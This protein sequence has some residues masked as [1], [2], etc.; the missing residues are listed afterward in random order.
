MPYECQEKGR[1][2]KFKKK[3]NLNHHINKVN[4]AMEPLG[5][6]MSPAT[7]EEAQED[8]LKD[9]ETEQDDSSS[10]LSVH[11]DFTGQEHIRDKSKGGG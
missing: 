5:V 6:P 1:G 7:K 3:R 9:E 2:K 11:G 4:F 10:K 8:S